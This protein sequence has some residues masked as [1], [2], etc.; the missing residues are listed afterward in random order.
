M[1]KILCNNLVFDDKGEG[2]GKLLDGSFF[3]E[4]S[5]AEDELSIDTLEFSVRYPLTGQ[6][7]TSPTKFPYGTP[8]TYY[9]NEKLF[10]KFYLVKVERLSRFEYNFKFQ[11]AVGL[12]ND[13]THYGGIY[14]GEKADVIISDIIGGKIPYTIKEIFS[15]IKL[16]GW[17]PIATRRENLKQVLFA[18]GGTIKKNNNGDV[19]ITTL[20][21]T[22]PID[23]PDSRVFNGGKMSYDTLVSRVEVTEHGYIKSDDTEATKVFEGELSGQNFTTPKGYNVRNAALVTWDKPY[24]SLTFEGC[25]V[26]NDECGVNYAIVN[27]TPNAVITGKPYIHTEAIIYK[28]KANYNGEEKVATVEDATLVSLANSGS[29]AERVLAYYGNSNTLSTSIILDNEKP[30]NTITVT[31]PFGDKATGFIKN[32]DG[33]FGSQYERGDID[34]VLNY[35]PPTVVGSRT[36]VSIAVTTPPTQ[37]NYATGDYF[38]SSGMVVTATYDDGTTNILNSYRISPMD[39][40]KESDTEI[41]IT[42][43]ELGVTRS[44]TQA[45]SVVTMLRRIAI[46]TPPDNT[47]YYEEDVFDTTGMVVTAYYSDGSSKILNAGEYTYYP[48]GELTKND[49]TITITYTDTGVTATTY[50]DITVGNA[51]ILT[52]IS[53]TKNPDKMTY[54]L[55][56]FFDTTGM[57]VTASFDNGTSK[58]VN[59]YTY[60]PAGALGKNDTTITISYTKGGITKTTTL[61]IVVA[62]LVSISITT[63]PTYT[64]YYEGDNFNKYGMVVTANYSNNSTAVLDESAYTVTPTSLV[65][66]DTYVTISYTEQGI[67]ATTTQAVTVTYYPYDYTKSTVIS[68]SGTYHLSDF[69]ATHRNIRVVSISGGNGGYG[70]MSGSSGSDSRS[71]SISSGNTGS[72]SS[73]GGS[74][75]QGGIGG[76]EVEG[77]LFY[78]LDLV[79]DK[80]SDDIVINIGQGGAGGAVTSYNDSGSLNAGATGGE[81]T[82]RIGNA[83]IT[84]GSGS[85]S[86]SGYTNIFTQE[87]YALGGSAGHDAANGGSGGSY[88][89]SGNSGSEINGNYGGSGGRSSSSS[90]PVTKIEQ[91]GPTISQS[92]SRQT[93]EISGGPTTKSISGATSYTVNSSTG[94]ITTSG[95]RT[96]GYIGPHPDISKWPN[97]NNKNM[98]KYNPGTVYTDLSNDS[99]PSS[100]PNGTFYSKITEH[101]CTTS[102]QTLNMHIYQNATHNGTKKRTLTVS[103]VYVYKEHSITKET[104][105]GGG[106]GGGASWNSNGGSG[107]TGSGGRGAPG[108]AASSATVYGSSGSSGSG[109]GGGGGAGGTYASISGDNAYCR[110]SVSQSGFS[111]GSGGAGSAGG[112]GAQGCVIIYYS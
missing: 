54:K 67:T 44:T 19:Y 51:P 90:T 41:T 15:K 17:L 102:N 77:G 49:E 61:T 60:S 24:H 46:T 9:Q 32:I 13:T 85:S 74:G 93:T 48:T 29:T 8:C 98:K 69:G 80:A 23:I 34:V 39:P 58:P 95:Y 105:R 100:R 38:D 26:L 73:S 37:V 30:T 87:T 71:S 27:A 104:A 109:G 66:A 53:I 94:K 33:T 50:Q 79:L 14:Q 81:T 7:D 1:N 75:G 63:P 99:V 12:L 45:I 101:V 42:Y 20:D 86:S 40:L 2:N 76:P 6:V 62:Y 78:A 108:P 52:G 18:C 56:Q 97:D 43:T 10:G 84:S 96:I 88:S 89:S 16:Y 68:T 22:T 107:S 72:R 5:L 21:T 106:G 55:G 31:D 82:C 59:G 47:A 64:E 4:N 28:N 91:K 3:V 111:G 92:W 11:S 36:L 110:E 103:R 25:S 65:C 83:T 70:G 112:N 35:V 57:V